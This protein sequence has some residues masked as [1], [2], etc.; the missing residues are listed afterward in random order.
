M[1][2]LTGI[3]TLS[4]ALVTAV[5]LVVTWGSVREAYR[6]RVDAV[7]PRVLVID[8]TL[9]DSVST[10]PASVGGRGVAE[11][12]K[13][14]DM[15]QNGTIPITVEV[16]VTVYN[17]GQM[18]AFVKVETQ[19]DVK[20][21]TVTTG[22]SASPPMALPI[23]SLPQSQD[24]WWLL[25]SGKHG[26]LRLGWSMPAHTWASLVPELIDTQTLPPKMTFTV[27]VRDATG[28]TLDRT[29][30]T[31]G[32]YAVTPKATQDGWEIAPRS[33]KMVMAHPLPDSVE[34]VGRTHRTYPDEPWSFR[35]K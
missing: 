3:G 8:V 6:A 17:E 2:Y 35:R 34:V 16:V 24:G 18:A 19:P 12:G 11:P 15:T 7:A 10:A 27:A 30:C 33:F 23:T 22:D 14:W 32:T 13:G 9:M 29:P 28:K 21:L 4:L 26:Y 20:T 25:K 1:D 5:A 31:V